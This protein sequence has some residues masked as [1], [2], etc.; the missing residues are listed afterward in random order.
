MDN[1][2]ENCNT[3]LNVI[4]PSTLSENLFETDPKEV[5]IQINEEV[6]FGWSKILI[7]LLSV[8]IYI[9]DV[10]TDISIAYFHY[11]DRNYW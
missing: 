2:T 9:I 6:K 8:S 11:R 10:G 1:T 3:E 4:E 7:I 5:D